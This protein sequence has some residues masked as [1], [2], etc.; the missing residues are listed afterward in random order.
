MEKEECLD[1]REL[2]S[3]VIFSSYYILGIISF[4]THYEA[5]FAV[6]LFLVTV[7]FLVINIF[8]NK[9]AIIYYLSFSLALLNCNFQIKN[10]DDQLNT[11]NFH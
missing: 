5:Y 1:K 9:S 3:V 6:F 7:F 4:F 2:N 8:S 11:I 10:H